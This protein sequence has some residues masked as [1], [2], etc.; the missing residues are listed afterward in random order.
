[1]R[2]ERRERGAEVEPGVGAETI[3]IDLAFSYAPRVLRFE[4][5]AKGRKNA[6]WNRIASDPIP[7]GSSS[8][9]LSF[10]LRASAFGS[11]EP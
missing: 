10:F 2:G 5:N 1:M 6:K 8:A 9:P 4:R 3:R 7:L 11:S